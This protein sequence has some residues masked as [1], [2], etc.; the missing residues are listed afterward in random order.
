MGPSTQDDTM[1]VED[2]G[3]ALQLHGCTHSIGF[4]PQD[5]GQVISVGLGT[6][7]PLVCGAIT[8]VLSFPQRLILPHIS[9]CGRLLRRFGKC[10]EGGGDRKAWFHPKKWL[11]YW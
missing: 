8:S 4:W 5:C 9:L 2:R 10:D 11:C 6:G 3:W 7:N 1:E